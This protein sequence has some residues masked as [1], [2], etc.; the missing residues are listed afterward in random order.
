MSGVVSFTYCADGGASGSRVVSG[1]PSSGQSVVS[2][3]IVYS[4]DICKLQR[5]ED[6]RGF[7]T[8]SGLG[9]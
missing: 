4:L 9:W 7:L 3:G 1:C 8:V 5:Y 6:S 2:I